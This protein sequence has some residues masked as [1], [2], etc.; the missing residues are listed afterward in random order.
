MALSNTVVGTSYTCNGINTNFPITF[1]YVNANQIKVFLIEVATGAVTPMV[2][3]TDYLLLPDDITPTSV[4]VPS[5]PLAAFNVRVER[6]SALQQTTTYINNSGFHAT[7]H[8]TGLDKLAEMIQELDL[9]AQGSV[10]VSRADIG[11]NMVLGKLNANGLLQV[12]PAGNAVI[13]G[14]TLASQIQSAI[15]NAGGGVP[16]GGDEY[17]LVEKQSSTDGDAIWTDPVVYDGI[18]ARFGSLQFTSDGIKDT[19]DKIIQITYTAP[20]LSFSGSSNSGTREK[21][22][23]VAS[24][25][26]TATFT[27]KSNPIATVRFYQGASLLDTQAVGPSSGVA[28]FTYSTPFS[29]NI[30]FSGQVDDTLVG[31]NGPTTTTTATSYT[32]VYPYYYGAGATGKT[33]AQI[34][35]DLTKDSSAVAINKIVSFTALVGDRLYFAYPQAS[36]ALISILDVNGFE[37]LPDWTQASVSITGLDATSQTY[38]VYTFNNLV[39]VAGTIPYTFKR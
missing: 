29:D 15:L 24:V 39:G 37:T 5:A 30:T 21:G 25:T 4:S 20:A 2:L 32:F 26:L 3:V 36:S 10:R 12:N 9:K 27:K 17:A 7:D 14:D 19:L 35:S 34:R 11:A 18:S 8:E 38:R 28:T 22:A 33:G 16:L 13:V 31:G 23:S 6:V 1:D